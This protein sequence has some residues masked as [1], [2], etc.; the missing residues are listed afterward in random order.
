VSW[1]AVARVFGRGSALDT[2]IS[3]YEQNL[4]KKHLGW[5]G[6][7]SQSFWKKANKGVDD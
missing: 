7:S 5:A 4:K 2:V 1:I 6:G 3:K